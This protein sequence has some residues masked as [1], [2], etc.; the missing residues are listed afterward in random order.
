MACLADDSMPPVA[1]IAEGEESF[2]GK[3]LTKVTEAIDLSKAER[4]SEPDREMS[5]KLNFRF[6]D[7]D[8]QSEREC[9]ETAVKGNGIDVSKLIPARVNDELKSGENDDHVRE[10]KEDR[11][12]TDLRRAG[13]S[14]GK[15]RTRRHATKGS[16]KGIASSSAT[17][18]MQCQ[19]DMGNEPDSAWQHARESPGCR[20]ALTSAMASGLL[21]VGTQKQG[22]FPFSRPPHGSQRGGGTAASSEAWQPC[23]RDAHRY[24]FEV[25]PPLQVSGQRSRHQT[26][27]TEFR[28]PPPP[29]ASPLPQHLLRREALLNLSTTQLATLVNTLAAHCETCAFCMARSL[30]FMASQRA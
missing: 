11:E 21:S 24:D 22:T 10:S 27:E 7:G 29:P 18:C 2:S 17:R 28:V 1:D 16:G 3:D 26:L 4:L 12:G 5:K 23:Q 8:S 9:V 25:P 20:R 19:R 30:D 14:K 15:G 6:E 13:N